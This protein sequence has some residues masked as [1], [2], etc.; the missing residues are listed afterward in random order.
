MKTTFPYLPGLLTFREGPL[1]LRIWE[2]I[3]N[4]PD[5]IIFDGQ[6]IAHPR[7]MELAT[8][9]GILLNKPSIGCAKTHLY[10]EYDNP[11]DIKGKYKYIKENNEVIGA[12]LRT[13]NGVK[14]VFVSPGNLINLDLSIEIILKCMK[15]YRLPEPL[16]L[17]HLSSNQLRNDNDLRD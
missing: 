6:G 17:A 3:E 8:H 15:N 16:R 2:K 7:R 5:I 9:L 4:K 14:P 11:P 12:V 1:I 10:G 13:K